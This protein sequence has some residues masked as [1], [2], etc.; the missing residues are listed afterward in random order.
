MRDILH[1]PFI[2]CFC[3]GNVQYFLKHASCFSGSEESMATAMEST[4]ST[5]NGLGG[6]QS[7]GRLKVQRVKALA[8]RHSQLKKGSREY[9]DELTHEVFGHLHS[10][11][12]LQTMDK[13][14]GMH[15][16][17]DKVPG[18]ERLRAIRE[19]ILRSNSEETERHLKQDKS[20]LGAEN[21][22]TQHS[23][24][25][26]HK[27]GFQGWGKGGSS[28]DFRAES[29][30]LLKQHKKLSANSDFFSR[31]S[32]T[33][34]GCSEFLVESLRKQLFVCPSHIQVCQ[35]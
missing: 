4:S 2:L 13:K 28:R 25:G 3:F 32:F 10:E 21:H 19:S 20:D 27:A 31:K 17:E 9:D 1:I 6:A 30:D 24:L 16:H 7:F 18:A 22:A 29:V 12:E 15:R 8:K 23:G 11:V 5:A 33:D 14:P 35:C 34:L 26:G